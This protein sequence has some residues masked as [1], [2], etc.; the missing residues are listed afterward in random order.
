MCVVT[1]IFSFLLVVIGEAGLIVD[2]PLGKVGA[3]PRRGEGYYIVTTL[4]IAH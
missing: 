4:L 2:D 1:H 3:S